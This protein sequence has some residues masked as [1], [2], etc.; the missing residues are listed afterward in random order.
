MGGTCDFDEDDDDD[1][2]G[3]LGS[4]VPVA[5]GEHGGAGEVVGIEVADVYGLVGN[6]DGSGPVGGGVDV[7]SQLDEDGLDRDRGT[8][9]CAWMKML[10]RRSNILSWFS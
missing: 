6:S 5:N 10:A 8:K 1:F 9:M 3:V 4:D 7:G 2:A